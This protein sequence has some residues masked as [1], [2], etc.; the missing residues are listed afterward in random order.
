MDFLNAPSRLKSSLPEKRAFIFGAFDC[1]GPGDVELLQRA[2]D[3]VPAGTALAVGLWDDVVRGFDVA[4]G[5][6]LTSR[7]TVEVLTG[8]PPLLGHLERALA[9]VQCR[10]VDAVLL[11]SP[12]SP[13]PA[14]IKS[15]GVSHVVQFGPQKLHY[16]QVEVSRNSHLCYVA[17]D[18]LADCHHRGAAAVDHRCSSPKSPVATRPLHG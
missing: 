18:P 7:Q 11:Y 3:A 10:N 2:K 16:P 17:H 5:S 6:M 15:L 13:S 14:A 9:L 4:S 1:F 12:L 8:D